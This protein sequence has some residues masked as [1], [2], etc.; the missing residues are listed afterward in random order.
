M[1]QKMDRG[2]TFWL[3]GAKEHKANTIDHMF[4]YLCGYDAAKYGV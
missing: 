1:I 4:Y 3:K 2:L